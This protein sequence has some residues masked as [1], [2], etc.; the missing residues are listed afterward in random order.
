MDG[1]T[2][3]AKTGGTSTTGTSGF[4]D[5]ITFWNNG[6]GKEAKKA[7][8]DALPTGREQRTDSGQAQEAQTQPAQKS[9]H[10]EINGRPLGSDE[11][12]TGQ[13]VWVEDN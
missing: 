13:A 7:D 10:W 12:P 2:G 9:G 11:L 8:S 6:N 4:L 3:V 1:A 5:W